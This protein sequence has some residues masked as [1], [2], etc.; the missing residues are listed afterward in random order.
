[1]TTLSQLQASL[2]RLSDEHDVVLDHHEACGVDGE[3]AA[4][5]ELNDA[6]YKCLNNYNCR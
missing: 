2:L 1:M 6:K 5:E 4:E 3:N